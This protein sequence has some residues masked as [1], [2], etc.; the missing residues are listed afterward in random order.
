MTITT[1]SHSRGLSAN[2]VI[3]IAID[4]TR[5]DDFLSELDLQSQ[6][7]Q[8]FQH[9]VDY[10]GL[11]FAAPEIEISIV[12]TNDHA[13]QI[14]NKTYRQK[15][16]PT[17]VLSFGQFDSIEALQSTLKNMPIILGDIVIALE[18][19]QYEAEQQNKSFVDHFFHLL[20]HGF[21]HLLGYDHERDAET[22]LF[23]AIEVAV[24]DK[25]HITNPYQYEGI[26]D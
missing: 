16:K 20:M 19:L 11:I 2:F 1:S 23:E 17:N 18:T 12:L 15:D 8:I 3:D 6:A 7:S 24:L 5:W 25:L 4:D 10:I 14:L 22:E 21:I 26:N 9:V 13:I